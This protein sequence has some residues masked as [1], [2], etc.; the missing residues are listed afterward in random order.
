MRYPV[1]GAD[2][3]VAI[4]ED[5]LGKPASREEAVA[6]LKRLSGT[7]HLVHSAIAVKY[8]DRLE[9]ALSSTEV[10]MRPLE[11]DEIR[12]YVATGEP[13][14][15]AGAYGI[16]GRASVFIERISG[17]YSGVVGLP[18]FETAQLLASFGLRT[19]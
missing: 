13:F 19:A 6:M 2:T 7:S 5:I 15:K 10:R 14:D 4:G 9:E 16:Q 1:L 8:N 18:I 12:R 3:T 11:D 17:S